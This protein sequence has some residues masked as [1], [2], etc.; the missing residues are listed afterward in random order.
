MNKTYTTKNLRRKL[1]KRI[2]LLLLIRKHVGKMAS[3]ND[4]REDGHQAKGYEQFQP[5]VYFSFLLYHFA[6]VYEDK[7]TSVIYHVNSKVQKSG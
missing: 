6:V 1:I 2:I 5:S 4:G 7:W 3:P